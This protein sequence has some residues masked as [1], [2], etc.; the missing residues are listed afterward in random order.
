MM[1][2]YEKR[3]TWNVHAADKLKQL[4]MENPDLPLVIL[5]GEDANDGDYSYVFCTSVSAEI[6]E[7]LDCNQEINDEICYTDRDRFEEDIMDSLYTDENDS[8]PDEW[9]EKET[10]R[11]AAEY[12]PYWTRCIIL[13]V[14]N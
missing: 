12:E 3:R 10:D 6:G 7:I 9:F 14:D 2:E 1:N 4:I 11:I 8:K 5:A 13:T